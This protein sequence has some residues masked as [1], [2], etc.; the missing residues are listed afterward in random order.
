[1]KLKELLKSKGW[2]D[3]QIDKAFADP[4]V[5]AILD[6]SLGTITSE[7]DQLKARD[8][9]W[10]TKLETEYNPAIAKAE[11]EAADARL[12]AA[13]FEEQVKIAKDYGYLAGDEAERRAAEAAE[14][15]K[16]NAG[17]PANGYDPKRHPTFD[18]VAKF[19]DAEGE[20]IAMANDLAQEYKYYTGKDLFEYQTELNG[21]TYRGMR[22]IR[23]EAKLARKPLDQFVAEKFDFRGSR[24]RKA[25]ETQKAHDD[26]IR[27]E[28]AEATRREMAEKYGNPN[29]A[30]PIPSRTPFLIE[31][32]KDGKQPWE[33]GTAQERKVQ[34]VQNAM[35]QQ[36]A[37][38]Q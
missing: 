20:A 14:R 3:E 11:R 36:V 30:Q 13:T 23:Q 19:A 6:E 28:T 5:I 9:E 29:L 31:K 12:R 24:Q 15:A 10:Q 2:T 16:V 25:E 32:S 37:S 8:A 34:R 7:R 33:R 22:A 21:Q 27:K 35:Q 4:S 1:M 38:G 17:V 18:D 26:Q